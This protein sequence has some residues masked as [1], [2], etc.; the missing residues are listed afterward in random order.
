VGADVKTTDNSSMPSPRF[1]PLPAD[2]LDD[3]QRAVIAA[4]TDGPRGGVRGPFHALLRK[5]QLAERVRALGDSIRFENTLPPALRE[6]AILIVARYWSARYE[7]HA[8]S[9]LAAELGVAAQTIA[10]I[11]AGQV[12]AHLTADEAIVFRFC[13]ELLND[14]D[15]GD[16][17]YD[18]A[19][20]RFG[21]ATVLDLIA[22]AGYF[23]FVSLILNAI[24]A[25]V[26]EGGAALPE[27]EKSR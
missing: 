6:F 15:V 26:P 5:P 17:T 18:A 14:K 2:G 21:E 27:L 22:T 4:L 11:G 12:P 25:P 20:T 10:A 13:N 8:H 16:A 24:R 9:R 19:L 23:G 7:W 3:A 1:A